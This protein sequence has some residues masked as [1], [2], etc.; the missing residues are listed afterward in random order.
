MHSPRDGTSLPGRAVAP[1]RGST[2]TMQYGYAQQGYGQQGYGQQ[3]GYGQQQ[4]GYGQQQGYGQQNGYG[5]QGGS[6]SGWQLCSNTQCI[7]V[8]SNQ[9]QVLGRYDMQ[10]Q[11]ITVSRAQCAV[12]M[13][14]DG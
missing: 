7:P 13:Q 2:V 11:K 4:G 12:M 8:P 9:E 5:Q 6:P 10:N 1:P 3:G 14:Q